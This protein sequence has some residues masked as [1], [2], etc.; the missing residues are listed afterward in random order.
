MTSITVPTFEKYVAHLDETLKRDPLMKLSR[1]SKSSYFYPENNMGIL[2]EIEINVVDRILRANGFEQI[3][4]DYI[5]ESGV[6]ER[7]RKWGEYVEETKEYPHRLRRCFNKPNSTMYVQLLIPTKPYVQDIYSTESQTFFWNMGVKGQRKIGE[8]KL[9]GQFTFHPHGKVGDVISQQKRNYEE[10]LKQYKS[11]ELTEEQRI[12]VE[13]EPCTPKRPDMDIVD[14]I[15][16]QEMADLLRQFSQVPGSSIFYMINR[17]QII[18]RNNL[19][20]N[21]DSPQKTWIENLKGVN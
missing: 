10:W 7:V 17:A 21:Y 2:S 8:F 15:F 4:K 9:N 1:A 6:K 3:E 16:T 5:W 12:A 18:A 19:Q 14:R 11:M 13:G 20:L